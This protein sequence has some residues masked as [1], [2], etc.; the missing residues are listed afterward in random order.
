MIFYHH[1]EQNTKKKS[2]ITQSLQNLVNSYTIAWIEF[3]VFLVLIIGFRNSKML[4]LLHLIK[5]NNQWNCKIL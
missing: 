3:L 5:S 2:S 1:N 4:F